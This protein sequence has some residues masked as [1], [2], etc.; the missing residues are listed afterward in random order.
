MIVERSDI[1]EDT[2]ILAGA[3]CVSRNDCVVDV[4]SAAIAEVSAA[5]S[6]AS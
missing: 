1:I 2:K 3:Y 4:K 5:A 6:D